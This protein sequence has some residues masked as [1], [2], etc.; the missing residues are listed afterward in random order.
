M[1]MS[2]AELGGGLAQA[3]VAGCRSGGW[4][5]TGNRW[6]TTVRHREGGEGEAAEGTCLLAS[7]EGGEA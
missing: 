3:E 1:R 5:W 6:R 7:L 4:W 2:M